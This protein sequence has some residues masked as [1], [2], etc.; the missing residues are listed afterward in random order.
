MNRKTFF[1]TFFISLLVF[2]LIGGWIL[3]N[4]N[5]GGGEDIAELDRAGWGGHKNLVVFGTDKSGLRSDVIMIFSV[6]PKNDRL[7]LM[8]IPRDTKVKINGSNQKINSALSIG[9]ESLAIQ[10][11]KELTGIPIHDYLTVNFS[12]V[13][14]VIDELGGI[15][16]DVPC[17]MNYRDPDQDLYIN[18]KK[19]DQ[20]LDGEDSVK[21]L[22]FRQYPMGDLQ[23]N[24]VQQDFFRA[25]VE[26]KLNTKYIK[27]VPALYALVEENITSSLSASELLSYLNTVKGMKDPT[28]ETFELPVSIQDPYVVIKE[29]EADEI[30]TQYFGK[31]TNQE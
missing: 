19:G 5:I 3:M 12:A 8:S 18:I 2:L 27:K 1:K 10:K 20:L 9:E 24:Q 26:Q 23:R 21:V 4:R 22:R 29:A 16:F 15:Q 13:E 11:V 28:V 6:D 31:T 17:N 14:T 7:S 25:A 30:L